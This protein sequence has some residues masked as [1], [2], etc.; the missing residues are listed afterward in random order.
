MVNRVSSLLSLNPV[1]LILDSVFVNEGQRNCPWEAFFC[2]DGQK[3][4]FSSIE[5]NTA[6][7]PSGFLET[8]ARKRAQFCCS[9]QQ[10]YGWDLADAD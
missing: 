6:V 7:T 2:V 8:Y 10:N 5:D 4:D 3:S 9:L 1:K